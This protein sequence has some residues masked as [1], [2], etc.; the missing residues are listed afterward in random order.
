MNDLVRAIP[1][2]EDLLALEPEELGAK[3]LFLMKQRGENLISSAFMEQPWANINPSVPHYPYE[4]KAAGQLAIRE[5]WAWLLA[6]GLIIPQAGING[7]NGR[8]DLSRRAKRFESET[9]VARFAAARLL[10]KDQLHPRMADR[11][12]S[13]FIRGEF[14][15]AVFQAMKAV[16]VAVREAAGYTDADY[17]TEMIARAFNEDR[18]PL[19]D[20]TMQ[21]AER[22]ARRSLFVG[23]Y[24]SYKNPQS[25]RDVD[26]EDPFEATEIILLANHLLRIVD[27]RAAAREIP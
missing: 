2:I 18:G 4:R 22:T 16:E 1:K 15:V 12:W 10:A 19:R 11:V 6:Q 14:D 3:M 9:E 20:P 8:V 21:P 5:A 27:A 26:I 7:V 23:A 17:G 25:H 13:A 24:G